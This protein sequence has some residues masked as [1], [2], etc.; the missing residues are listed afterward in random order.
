MCTR[1]YLTLPSSHFITPTRDCLTS[2]SDDALCDY[3]RYSLR[4]K[5]DTASRDWFR[6]RK[7]VTSDSHVNSYVEIIGSETTSQTQKYIKTHLG[8]WPDLSGPR[9][10][11]ALC[12]RFNPSNGGG[13]N[14]LHFI[15]TIPKIRFQS[16]K[17][18][19][20]RIGQRASALVEV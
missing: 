2:L 9:T 10:L 11:V 6:H 20:T 13:G 16:R 5:T 19:K 3:W 4:W 8:P 17:W 12:D 1:D 7:I 14:K 18:V 15:T